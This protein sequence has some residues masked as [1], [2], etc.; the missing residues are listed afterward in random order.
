MFVSFYPAHM[1]KTIQVTV[2][3]L[4]LMC[5]LLCISFFMPK[6]FV[7]V[8]LQVCYAYVCTYSGLTTAVSPCNT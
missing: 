7:L 4:M 3:L 8:L 2:L 5:T 1:H 6:Q